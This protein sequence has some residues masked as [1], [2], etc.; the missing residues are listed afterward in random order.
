MV[1]SIGCPFHTFAGR[2]EGRTKLIP[3]CRSGGPARPVGGDGTSVSYLC[4]CWRTCACSGLRHWYVA[5]LSPF[6]YRAQTADV[7]C[8]RTGSPQWEASICLSIG[9]MLTLTS[10][11]VLHSE[12]LRASSGLQSHTH[13]AATAAGTSPAERC[14]HY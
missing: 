14:P 1:A 8:A 5:S 9:T 2:R 3:T 12:L 4:C 13:Q 7:H 10:S 11:V 6:R